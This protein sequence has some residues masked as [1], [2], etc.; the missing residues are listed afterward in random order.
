MPAGGMAVI[1]NNN[2][3][4]LPI[5]LFTALMIASILAFSPYPRLSH[6]AANADSLE[7]SD[8]KAEIMQHTGQDSLCLEQKYQFL[9]QVFAIIQNW[10]EIFQQ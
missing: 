5:A 10:I 4:R 1:L 3:N 7:N 8:L 2:P 9:L 6:Q